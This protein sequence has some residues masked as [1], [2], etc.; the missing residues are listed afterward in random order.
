MIGRAPVVDQNSVPPEEKEELLGH[1][2][3]LLA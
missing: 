2:A 3:A 1:E